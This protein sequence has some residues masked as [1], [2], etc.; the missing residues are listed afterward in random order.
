ML[1]KLFSLKKKYEQQA[2]DQ[3]YITDVNAASM[4]G[5]SIQIHIILWMAFSFVIIAIIWADFAELDEVTRGS[6]KTIP[7][8]HIQVIQNLEGGILAEILVREGKIVEKNKP[9]LQLDAVR[10]AS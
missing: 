9:I 3:A 10:F 6:G 4:Y 8:S 5:A 2:E 7:S 1:N